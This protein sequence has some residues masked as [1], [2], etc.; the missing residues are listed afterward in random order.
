MAQPDLTAMDLT[1]ELSGIYRERFPEALR[2]RR[3]ALWRTLYRA[4][5]SKFVGPKDKVLEIAP[6]Y[7]EFLN[8]LDPGQERVGVDLNADTASFAAPGI[9]IHNVNADQMA[10]VLPAGHFDVAFTSNFFEHCHSREQV[11]R[12]MRATREVLRPGGRFLILGP[13]FRYCG[14]SYFDYFDHHLPLTDQSLQEALVIAGFEI[15]RS[16]PRLLPFTMRGK[17]PSWSWLVA[18]YMKL[19]P[20]WRVFGAQFFIVARRG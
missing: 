10:Q 5:F 9:T 2:E 8:A 6:G 1:G 15:E 17:L 12:I 4:W 18:L 19:P 3:L 11:L 14:G 20:L 7:C 13:N 16:W